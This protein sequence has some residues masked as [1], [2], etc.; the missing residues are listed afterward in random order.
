VRLT[1]QGTTGSMS[2]AS[3]PAAAGGGHRLTIRGQAGAVLWGH[4]TA[5]ALGAWTIAKAERPHAAPVWHLVAR[6]TRADAFQCRQRPLRFTAFRPG[7]A[8]CFGIESL[9]LAGDRV[10]AVL[11]PPEQ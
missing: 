10:S 6:V 1:A 7:G 9:E 5:A 3:R 11:G 2:W 4:R 8:W